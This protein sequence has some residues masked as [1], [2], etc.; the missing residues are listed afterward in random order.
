MSAVGAATQPFPQVDNLSPNLKPPAKERN[1][2]ST[3]YQFD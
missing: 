1:E 2:A 3:R